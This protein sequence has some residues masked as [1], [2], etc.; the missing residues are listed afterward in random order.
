MMVNDEQ[1]RRMLE[2]DE[3]GEQL[4]FP[5]ICCSSPQSSSLP[6]FIFYCSPKSPPPKHAHTCPKWRLNLSRTHPIQPAY[7]VFGYF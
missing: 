3:D 4:N 1:E 6:F 2:N 7:T 5:F